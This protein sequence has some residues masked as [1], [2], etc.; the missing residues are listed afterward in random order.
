MQ[1]TIIDNVFD[2]YP[3]A[4]A[5]PINCIG[6]SHDPFS[7]KI[8][9]IWPDYY[10]EYAR[11]CIRKQLKP[12]HTYHYSIFALF[13]TNHILT[14][15]IRNNWQEKIKLENFDPLIESF[16]AHCHKQKISNIAIPI[17]EDIPQ[18]WYENEFIKQK[19]KF[20]NLS[21]S[22]VYFFKNA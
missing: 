9:R 4:I 17:I 12:Y 21:L 6:I 8:K 3:E 11:A 13:G 20:N 18:N 14:M 22:E 19:N 5:H 16:L 1:F 2:I 7:R 15:T 10:R